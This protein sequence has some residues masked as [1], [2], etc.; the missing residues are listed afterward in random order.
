M[1]HVD[2]EVYLAGPYVGDSRCYFGQNCSSGGGKIMILEGKV[3][4][5][6]DNVDTD[7]VFRLVI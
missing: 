7:V 2:S 5:Y 3:W 6:G 1:G 4:R